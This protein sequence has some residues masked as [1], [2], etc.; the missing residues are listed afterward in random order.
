LGGLRQLRDDQVARVAA[1]GAPDAVSQAADAPDGPLIGIRSRG[2]VVRTLSPRREGEFPR[3]RKLHL[4]APW[5]ALQKVGV[6]HS[7]ASPSPGRLPFGVSPE[8]GPV[9]VCS[10]SAIVSPA[11]R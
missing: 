2:V 4:E 5:P 9:W 10:S 1:G 11:L 7:Q 8:A 6:R 3:P